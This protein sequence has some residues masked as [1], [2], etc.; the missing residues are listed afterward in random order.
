MNV[1]HNP[2]ADETLCPFDSSDGFCSLHSCPIGSWDTFHFP[3]TFVSKSIL[4]CC[5]SGPVNT[6]K[7]TQII[8]MHFDVFYHGL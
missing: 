2:A 4:L 3:S 6:D 8:K 7:E 1:V 5:I